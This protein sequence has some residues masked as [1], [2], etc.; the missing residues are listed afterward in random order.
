MPPC[1]HSSA[2]PA[3]RHDLPS[4]RRL[5]AVRSAAAATLLP[6]FVLGG[7][8]NACSDTQRF[9]D[10]P[11]PY[12]PTSP[13]G[14]SWSSDVERPA[15]LPTSSATRRWEWMNPRPT[16]ETL[17]G[18]GGSSDHD[19]W[20]VGARGTVLHWDGARIEVPLQGVEDTTFHAV[21]TSGPDD[22]WLFGDTPQGSRL[23][24]WNGTAWSEQLGL[25]GKRVATVSSGSTKRFIILT[26]AISFQTTWEYDRSSGAWVELSEGPIATGAATD[27]WVDETGDAWVSCR[28]SRFFRRC[29]LGKSECERISISKDQDLDAFGIWGSSSNDINAFYTEPKV[30][31]GGL[32]QQGLRSL[33]FD[34]STWKPRDEI[35]DFIGG[36]DPTVMSARHSPPAGT[37]DGRR[38]AFVDDS[39]VTYIP[40]AVRKTPAAYN[41]ADATYPLHPSV[42]P[43]PRTKALWT[44]PSGTTFGVGEFGMFVR[45]DPT[46]AR[47]VELLPSVRENVGP[48][49]LAPDDGRLS[50]TR[51]SVLRWSTDRWQ[52][53]SIGEYEELSAVRAFSTQEAW[54]ATGG[55]IGRWTADG[56]MPI[57][58]PL[59]GG[60]FVQALWGEGG[61]EGDGKGDGTWAA[62]LDK[63]PDLSS[64]DWKDMKGSLC[65]GTKVPAPGKIS[66]WTC[67]AT[68]HRTFAISGTSASDVWF[69]GDEL[70]HWDGSKLETSTAF[71]PANRR[72]AGVHAR[73]KKDV[74]LWGKK[75][76]YFDGTIEVPLAEALGTMMDVGDGNVLS[77]TSD[78]AGNLYVLV[79]A[80]TTPKPSDEG[81]NA[82]LIYRYLKEDGS[83]TL[84]RAVDAPLRTLTARGNEIWATGKYGATLRL[85]DAPSPR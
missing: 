49:S 44:S 54:V 79:S 8:A 65:T 78:K 39:V 52:S 25:A 17:L 2:T 45:F 18:V 10:E 27:V 29:R 12:P 33:H 6:V 56:G 73:G 31:G 37:S 9:G 82:V 11:S 67:F 43:G 16:G 80:D 83:F 28:S 62:T 57:R 15:R 13:S 46:T 1:S 76:F 42:H 55:G 30:E 22:V 63:P 48:V 84:D 38:M 66:P 64:V 34:G 20:L 50:F 5:R 74:W 40:P 4:A 21:W 23:L 7:F 59:S 24:R 81:P 51:T 75:S 71:A 58:F 77:I 19:V 53:S 32:M 68:A 41:G 14:T 85:S 36:W 70:M 35:D 72:F 47:W 61:G 3:R 26:E 69:A 60:S